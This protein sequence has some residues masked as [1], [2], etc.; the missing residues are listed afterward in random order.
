MINTNYKIKNKY[1]P[2]FTAIRIVKATPEEFSY[3]TSNYKNFCSKNFLFRGESLNHANFYNSLLNT[4]KKENKSA[5]WIIQNAQRNGLVDVK[6]LD[7]LP[8]NVFT[9]KDII[10]FA[11]YTVKSFLKN[12]FIAVDTGSK[13][14]KSLSPDFPEHLIEPL[15]M[16]NFADRRLPQ[17]QKFLKKHNAKYVDYNEFINELQSGKLNN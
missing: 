11:L 9:G 8:I 6:K 3:L 5:H 14:R 13:T 2:N 1:S 17:Y 10:R 15:A 16:K 12:L 4:A 7:N